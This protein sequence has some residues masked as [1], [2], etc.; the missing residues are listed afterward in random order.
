DGWRFPLSKGCHHR[1]RKS[2]C[3]AWIVVVTWAL[4]AWLRARSEGY[5]RTESPVPLTHSYIVSYHDTRCTL[6]RMEP[7]EWASILQG[8]W[9]LF[10][11]NGAVRELQLQCIGCR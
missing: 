10:D 2:R 7:H 8:Y 11:D 6:Y 5:R 3:C 1:R 9:K 4:R